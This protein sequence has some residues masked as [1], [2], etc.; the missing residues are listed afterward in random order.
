MLIVYRGGAYDLSKAFCFGLDRDTGRTFTVSFDGDN[1]IGVVEYQDKQFA[2]D[3]WVGLLTAIQRRQSL[4]E[5][6]E[7]ATNDD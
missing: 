4:Y 6:P 3:A 1:F 7:E 5:L 2:L